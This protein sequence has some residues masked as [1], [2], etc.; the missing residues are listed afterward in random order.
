MTSTPAYSLASGL[1]KLSGLKEL[2]VFGFEGSNHRIGTL[3]LD[4][5]VENWPKLRMLRGLEED[6][7]PQIRFDKQKAFL[8][9]HLRRL[10]PEVQHESL[11][12][13]GM[14]GQ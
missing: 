5:M 8:R 3:E 4:W 12:A 6:T 1:G 13:F 2:K 14:Q 9:E 11:G 7:L 10:R